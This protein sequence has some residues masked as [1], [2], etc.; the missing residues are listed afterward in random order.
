MSR[1][2][3][4]ALDSEIL[5][6][7]M[8]ELEAR[9]AQA[10]SVIKR[11]TENEFRQD[12]LLALMTDAVFI[13]QHG[14]V[15]FANQAAAEL[16]GFET[17]DQLIGVDIVELI[18]PDELEFVLSRRRQLAAGV[19]AAPAERRAV[20]RD[21]ALV[22]CEN[23]GSLITWEGAPAILVVLRD[24]TERKR[25]DQEAADKSALLGTTLEMMGHGYSVFDAES[26]LVGFNQKYVD[27]FP[28]PPGF[29]RLGLRH[30]EILRMLATAGIF[31]DGDIEELV[32]AR[33]RDST[34]R[35]ALT[36]ENTLPDGTAYLYQR[37]AMPNG[38]FVAT[39]TDITAR[40]QAE[41]AVHDSEARFRGLI[42]GSLLGIQIATREKGKVFANRACVDLFG[43]E[44]PEDLLSVS[45]WGLV[46]EHDR[47]RV[48][49]YRDKL[50][51]GEAFPAIYEF[52][53]VR[54]DG[55]V[56]PIQAIMRRIVWQGEDAIQRTFLDLT[57][58]KR[59]EEQ[60]RQAQ[61]MEAVGQL[62]G[63]VAHDFNNLL[64]VIQGNLEMMAAGMKQADIV[65]LAK[66]ALKATE[67]GGQ[68][69]QRLL[70]FSR[71][72]TLAPEVIRL[73]RLVAGMSD[74][75][76]R[77]LGEAI[78]IEVTTE[79]ELWNCEIDPGQLENAILNLALNARDA[80]ARGG[81]LTI[82]TENVVLDQP[83][84]V[85]QIVVPPGAYVRVSVVDTGT[86]LSTEELEHAFE[87]FFTT[88]EVGAGSGLGLSMVHGFISQSDGF[89]TIDSAQGAGAA[90]RMYLPKSTAPRRPAPHGARSE[91]PVARGEL[92]LVV[93]DDADVRA[94][95]VAL[96]TAEGYRTV[97]ASDG[98]LA[99]E[100]LRNTPGIDLLFT[101]VVL[102]GGISGVD[103]ANNAVDLV[104]GVKVLFAS[105]Y[106][107]DVLTPNGQTFE[108]F[109]LLRKP[110]RKADLARHIRAA[111]DGVAI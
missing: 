32:R 103:V 4:S 5:H 25:A 66:I 60:L 106:A 105:G 74:M 82:R 27:L 20:R 90:V 42:E 62:T 86:G 47:K 54:K 87:P 70:A 80:M 110:F 75:M 39:C 53:G 108:N 78:E 102:P 6:Q 26:R 88:K 21:G 98:K 111:L 49:G 77:T 76:R 92:I 3:R 84:T 56:V 33:H 97:E 23:R 104:P 7:Q 22:Q 67:R 18:H 43:Y 36:R 81:R 34:A 10:Q 37:R 100:V 38:G 2:Q 57:E 29:I 107:D 51:A 16:H 19:T 69:T 68:L 30:E 35:E 46:A 72:Q 101:D 71:K 50:F 85:L 109:Q 63:G 96:L 40:K 31:G 83:E 79:S 9:L 64:T 41:Q 93:E 73:D 52:D 58:H 59:A 44:S 14:R 12:E 45:R 24:I 61:K 48:R 95:T 99:M 28:F 8:S 15:V 89:V 1:V 91:A 94:L 55:S 17:P 11:L 13:Q 65:R